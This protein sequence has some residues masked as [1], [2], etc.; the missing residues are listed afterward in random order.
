[1]RA[2]LRGTLAFALLATAPVALAQDLDAEDADEAPAPVT[3]VRPEGEYSGVTPGEAAGKAAKPRKTKFPLVTWIG[4]QAMEGG[5]SRLFVQVNRDTQIDQRV[6][7]DTLYI[8][9]VGARPGSK[10]DVR[11]IDTTYFDAAL[12]EVTMRRVSARKGRKAGIELA[13]KFKNAGDAGTATS[14]SKMGQDGYTYLMLD[15]GPGS[16]GGGN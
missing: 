1:M 5:S 15:F 13:V 3:E 2:M 11:R 16:A 8:T 4:F 6:E 7:G 10:N 12:R 9:L 14:S